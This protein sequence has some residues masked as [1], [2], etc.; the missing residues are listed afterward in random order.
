MLRD[1]RVELRRLA[2]PAKAAILR[3]FFK[4]GPGEYGEGD[5]FL[6]IQVPPLRR[7]ARTFRQ[8]PISKAANLL[9]ARCHEERLLGL[10]LLVQSYR[11]GDEATRRQVYDLY[12]SCTDRINNWDL[13]DLS[14]P[15]IVGAH[16]ARRSRGPLR[17]LAKSRS[18]W[19]RR[20]A[21]VSTFHFI[22]QNEFGDTL[23]IAEILLGDEED[24]IRKATGWMLREVGKRDLPALEAFLLRHGPDMP[25]TMLRYAIER[26]P[27]PRR[28]FYL[29]GRIA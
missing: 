14:A 24:L 27:E 25:R 4:T 17:R 15:H 16:L 26:L 21:V 12:L 9:A 23:R 8:L 11:D 10:L 20:I 13:V 5:V 3:R 22:R 1:I 28:Q 7:L 2:N 6:G 18:L 29:R 19:E